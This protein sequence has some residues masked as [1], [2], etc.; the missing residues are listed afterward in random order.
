MNANWFSWVAI[1]A[2]LAVGIA[3]FGLTTL[4][5]VVGIA[6]A[7]AIFIVAPVKLPGD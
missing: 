2:G 3:I 1:A 7:F 4:G 5:V 6:L